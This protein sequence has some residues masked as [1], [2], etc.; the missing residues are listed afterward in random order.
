MGHARLRG[1][2]YQASF[3]I[4]MI[5]MAPVGPGVCSPW[6]EGRKGEPLSLGPRVGTANVRVRRSQLG[7]PET[8][9]AR[10]PRSQKQG[11][12]SEI[13]RQGFHLFL[14]KVTECGNRKK[15]KKKEVSS[16]VLHNGDDLCKTSSFLF[17]T[18][19]QKLRQRTCCWLILL[20]HLSLNCINA[21]YTG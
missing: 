17:L 12:W 7:D 9:R 18:R 16:P 5:C 8:S 2:L 11:S 14:G 4:Y 10:K 15:K 1:S 21:I 13:Q 3:T 6:E 20:R 19:S